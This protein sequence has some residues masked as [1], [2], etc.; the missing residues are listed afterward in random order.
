[1]S[2]LPWK[3][4]RKPRSVATRSMLEPGSVTATKRAPSSPVAAQK[5]ASSAFG[6]TVEPDFELTTKSEPSTG[7]ART[8]SGSVVSTTTSSRSA[9]AAPTVPR[10]S[11]AR[12]EPPIPQSTMR[13]Y[14]SAAARAQAASS[15]TCSAIS[16]STG[17]QPSQRP[18]SAAV[19]GSSDQRLPS[20]AKQARRRLAADE[21]AQRV[22]DGAVAVDLEPA[23]THRR[24]AP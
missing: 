21:L 4:R 16:S 11:G 8:A 1:M 5:C 14:G 3:M 18:I 12:L 13:S 20:P 22:A 15:S 23:L 10:T 2:G 9:T 19:A 6:S 7:T 17:S 24:R